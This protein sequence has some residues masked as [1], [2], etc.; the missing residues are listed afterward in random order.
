[1]NHSTKQDPIIG[2]LGTVLQQ[3]QIKTA[4]EDL[5]L[6]GQD[7][8]RFYPPNPIAVVFPLDVEDVVK[9]VHLANAESIA[10]VP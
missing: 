2:K 5:Q 8:T 1:M 7:W 10:L 4:R 9:L 3:S 6:Y